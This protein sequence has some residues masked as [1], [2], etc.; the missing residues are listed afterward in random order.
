LTYFVQCPPIFGKS[1]ESLSRNSA[2]FG[3]VFERSVR[4]RE[5]GKQVRIETSRDLI[6]WEF[7]A[8][9]PIPAGGQT[10]IDPVA[11]TEPFRFY[12]A[13]ALR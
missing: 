11:V 7:V 6:K 4:E 3:K 13:I 2:I 8:T 1:R 5:P 10:L 12:R 9:I